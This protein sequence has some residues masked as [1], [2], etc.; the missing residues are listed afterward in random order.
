MTVL[1]IAFGQKSLRYYIWTKDNLIYNNWTNGQKPVFQVTKKFVIIIIGQLAKSKSY[2][3]HLAKSLTKV[4]TNGN[5]VLIAI[6]FTITQ[7]VSLT[8]EKWEKV[9]FFTI[10]ALRFLSCIFKK[11]I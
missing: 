3:W 7:K 9:E 5:R 4:F 11:S 1:I 6:H 2:K 10:S 8:N